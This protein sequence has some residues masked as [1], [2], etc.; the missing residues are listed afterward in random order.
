MLLAIALLSL[1]PLTA[2]AL[3]VQEIPNPRRVNS[4]WVTDMA[5]ILSNDT[6]VQLNQMIATLEAKNGSEM[7][8]VTV[9]TT[10]PAPSPKI[11]ATSLFNTWGLGKKGLNNGV[12]FLISTGDR[13]VEIETGKGISAILPDPR[14]AKILQSQVVPQLQ[15]GNFE[16]GI[17]AGAIALIQALDNGFYNPLITPV[18]EIPS[19]FWFVSAILAV[20][21]AYF[22]YLARL[23]MT[24]PI[25]VDPQSYVR[26]DR[27]SSVQPQA[28]DREL[29]VGA[30]FAAAAIAFV[31]V[32]ANVTELLTLI[33][34]TVFLGLAGAVPIYF[35][36][37]WGMVRQ[38]KA[39]R[40]Q[41]PYSCQ[42]CHSRMEA[43][44]PDAL[45]QLLTHPEVTAQQLGSVKFEGW[46]CPQCNQVASRQGI[47][48]LAQVQNAYE[49][50][51]CS[52]CKELTVTSKVATKVSAT[53]KR[54]GLR[55]ITHTCH[56]CNKVTLHQETIA[57]QSQYVSSGDPNYSSY[58]SN[59]I[60]D[61]GSSYGGSYDSGSSGSD[62]G[63]GS[64]D[65]GGAGSDY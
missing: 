3:S 15:A 61:S 43:I 39:E 49:F 1:F 64:S 26:L 14:V 5:N 55:E 29:W 52:I 27:P 51:E 4:G 23:R 18:L 36:V 41:Y 42:K 54:T 57:K 53:E 6:E 8:I 28:S 48:L 40:S 62:F 21:S 30:F 13:R 32:V 11:F 58:D 45:T 59:S 7:A 65:G 12:L 63:G 60:Y 24:K 10:A 19:H 33:A 22:Y 31:L 46:H 2:S 38:L 50:Q 44:A 20:W 17:L 9:P 34:L 25:L 56:S 37:N 16:A 35:G 47:Y